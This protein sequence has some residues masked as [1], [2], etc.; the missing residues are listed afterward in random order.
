MAEEMRG[1]NGQNPPFGAIDPAV[2]EPYILKDPEAMTVNLARAVQ[3]AGKAASLWLEP[4]EKGEIV[5]HVVE[6]VGDM[7]RTLSKVIEYWMTDPKR[8]LEARHAS[9]AP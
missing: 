3:N 2:F 7:V 8:T 1:E 4:R 9:W 5:D 6:T